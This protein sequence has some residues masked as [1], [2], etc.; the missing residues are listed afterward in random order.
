M[1]I[2]FV[3]AGTVG[4]SVRHRRR[5]FALLRAIAATP[6]QVR[7]LI[8]GEVGL[9][10]LLASVVGVPAGLLAA[11]WIRDQLVTRGFVPETFA[12]RGGVLSALAVTGAVA[13]VALVSAWIAALR[14]T[15]IRPTEALGEAAVERA[16]G[17]KVRVWCGLAFLATAVS[18]IGLTGATDGTTALGAAVSML[19]T[20]VLAVALLAPWINQ[21][22]ARWLAPVLRVVWGTSGYLAAANLRANARGM[23]AVLSALVLSVG[24]GGTVW[25]LQDNLE[26]Q[27]VTQSHDGTLAQHA[28]VS[29]AGLP[30]TAAAAARKIPGVVAATGVRRT[31]VLVP[32]EFEAQTV[33]AQGIDP[34]GADQTLD[35]GVRKGSLAELRSDTMAVS[36]TQASAAGWKLGDNARLWLGDGTPVTLRVIAIYDRGWGFG[37]VTLHTEA[38]AGH[39]A[40]G[41]DD[42]VLIRT[43]PG[44][45][46]SGLARAY[47]ASTVIGTD[48]LTGELARDLAISAWL[49]KLLIGVLVGYAV[50]AAANTLIMAA[51]AR[52]RELSLLRLVGVTRGQVR[53]MVHAEQAGLLGVALA[54]GTT[55]AAVT[56]SSVVNAISGERIPYV[57]GVGVL[58]I[59]GGTVALALVAT[60]LPIG[61]VLRTPPIEGIGPR[62]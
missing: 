53:R 26:R 14:T 6:G 16:L 57:P 43:S 56:L 36:E 46:L 7:L 8:L 21:A 60:M 48:Q 2:I 22:A 3:A 41:L 40:T 23:V 54:I 52:S 12:L 20:F 11:A 37:D 42:R 45:D 31:S 9:L 32:G 51:L 34:R 61:R 39:T 62:E 47:P 10:T 24:F 27:T 25:F 5:D 28:L 30:T 58:T 50:L 13:L 18:L 44:A 1:I 59:V 55:I 38:L 33:V 19:Y 15:G 4:L 17:S 29:A 35:L 49:N